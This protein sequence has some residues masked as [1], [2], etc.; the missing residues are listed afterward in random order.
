LFC[1]SIASRNSF[2]RVKH[3]RLDFQEA[4]PDGT[5]LIVQGNCPE[6]KTSAPAQG[7]LVGIKND[8]AQNRQVS[9][10]EA[11]QEAKLMG[12]QYF[13]CSNRTFEGVVE[14][15]AH[16]TSLCAAHLDQTEPDWRLP[17][18]I[19]ANLAK[20]DERREAKRRAALPSIWN[21]W[22]WPSWAKAKLGM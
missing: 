20:E 9:I 14:V 22:K 18:S 8:F 4:R 13:E 19:I 12:V 6:Y 5:R 15:F 3:H 11:E 17:S 16:L 2:E 21:L 10:E 1:F 7:V